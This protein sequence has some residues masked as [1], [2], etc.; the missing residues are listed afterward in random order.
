MSLC[1]EDIPD[2]IGDVIATP[3]VSIALQ[4][5]TRT[6]SYGTTIP[7]LCSNSTYNRQ[8]VMKIHQR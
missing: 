3:K 6:R 8:L 7:I 4:G 1:W 5:N 2:L